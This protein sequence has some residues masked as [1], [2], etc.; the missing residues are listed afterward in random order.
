VT[1]V[2]IVHAA[3]IHLDSPLRGLG[4]FVK[5]DIARQLRQA[6]RQSLKNLVRL[7]VDERAAALVLAG[8]IY[9]GDWP[10]FKTGLYFREQ[11]ARLTKQ[12]IRV[13]VARGNH[14][15]ES[16]ITK[17]L[18]A[19]DG[20]HVFS[21]KQAETV[22]LDELGVAL[23][24]RS[25]PDKAVHEDLVPGYPPA[26]PGRYNIG[27]L[28]TSLAGHVDHVPYAPTT[29]AAL[30]SKGYDYFA[31]GHIHKREVVRVSNPRIV[32][33]GNLQGRHAKETGS[34]GCELVVVHDGRLASA[35]HVS[36][37]VVRWHQLAIDATGIDDLDALGARFIR[38]ATAAAAGARDKLHVMRVVIAGVSALEA[39]EAAQ[40]GLLCAAIQAASQD[41]DGLELWI[42][43]VRCEL[44]SPIDRGQER[45][46]Q[47]AIGDVIR[48][49]DELMADEAALHAWAATQLAEMKHLPGGLHDAAPASLS[50]DALKA[51]LID[52]ERSLLSHLAGALPRSA[53]A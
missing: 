25:F 22:T 26:V 23:H 4:G 47:D 5:E 37:D 31:L 2:R 12:G 28:H 34:K 8:D 44:R 32:Y 40:P 50:A 49:V 7:T 43:K 42:E 11:M 14:D 35:E 53:D 17:A 27:V 52:A 33:P 20:L 48:L 18:P 39:A 10:D 29:E 15:A 13:F 36:L 46:R 38:E 51:A 3:D 24:G 41:L 21:A 30:A 19:L 45:L 1:G 6:S 9:D 16:V